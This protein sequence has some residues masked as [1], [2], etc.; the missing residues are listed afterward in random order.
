[1]KHK[2]LVRKEIIIKSELELFY[3]VAFNGFLFITFSLFFYLF[4]AFGDWCL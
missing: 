4:D 2:R 3:A 1:M